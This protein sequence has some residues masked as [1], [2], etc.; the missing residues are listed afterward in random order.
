MA[1]VA[2]GGPSRRAGASRTGPWFG[3]DPSRIERKAMKSART[4][5]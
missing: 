2:A 5:A 1:P 3:T 4:R